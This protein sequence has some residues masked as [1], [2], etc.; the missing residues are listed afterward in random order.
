M[1][2]VDAIVNIPHLG[3]PSDY[4]HSVS[5]VAVNTPRQCF[6]VRI[7]DDELYEEAEMFGIEAVIGPGDQL[8]P[9]IV[10]PDPVVISVLDNDC[11]KAVQYNVMYGYKYYN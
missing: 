8:F 11:K 2:Q 1:H 3:T 9:V 10:S 7:T 4:V 6:N 5:T